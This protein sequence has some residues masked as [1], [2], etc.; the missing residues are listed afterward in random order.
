MTCATDQLVTET[1][2]NYAGVW[3]RHILGGHTLPRLHADP[4]LLLQFAS[5]L[6]DD[7]AGPEG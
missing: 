3:D 4:Q 7:G 2:R 1:R 6:A 5:D